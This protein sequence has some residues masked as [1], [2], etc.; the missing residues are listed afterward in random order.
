MLIGRKEELREIREAYKSE[1]SQFVAVYGRRRVGKTFLIR[2]AFDYTFTF[3]H[4]GVA[5]LKM[6]GQLE[7]FRLSLIEQG[8]KECPILNSWLEAF[9]E[10]KNI[11]KSSRKKKKVI[12]IDEISWMDTPK[13]NFL[14]AFE[15][16]WNGWCSARKDVLL[17]I[18]ASA[19]SWIINKVLKDRGGLHN[20]VSVRIPLA[21]FTLK[22]CEEYL[23]SRNFRISRYQILMLYM[24]MGGPAYY[25]SLL[26]KSK[27]AAQN[28]DSLFFAENGKLKNEYNALY[29]SLF[30]H[31]ELYIKIVSILGNK[32]TGLTRQELVDKYNLDASGTLTRCLEE[33]EE[34]GF[35][36]RYN[37]FG[38]ESKGA[39]YQLIDN[40]TLFY[41]KFIKE[42]DGDVAFWT[43]SLNT[44]LQNTWC[45]YAFERVCL[46]H[47]GQIKQALGI[48]AVST[49]QCSWRAD[50]NLLQEGERG[51]QIDLLIDRK[52]DTINIC[53]MKWA[54]GPFVIK[55]D[56]DMELR[57]KVT[58][59]VRETQTRKAV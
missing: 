58:A 42:A 24:V 7:A 45:G 53:E 39:V 17:I 56:Y 2:E 14:Q 54:S 10:L 38:K 30:K 47:I 12:F 20:R 5:K 23:V 59:F 31:P 35:I 40:Y 49:K 1:Y 13:S 16:F 51:A 44:S 4:T 48:G 41:F 15:N 43:N 22:E 8:H 21:P 29:E 57:N 55:S 11:I 37:A 34:C 6:K 19:T 18:C 9:N 36:R 46:Q 3:Q 50:V 32:A 33:L 28:I 27:S 52:D 26:N 25:W